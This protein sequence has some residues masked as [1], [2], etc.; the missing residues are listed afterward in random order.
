MK[1]TIAVIGFLLLVCAC[2]VPD[3]K[4]VNEGVLVNDDEKAL[5]QQ[6]LEEQKVLNDSA[7]IYQDSRLEEYL[8]TVVLRLQPHDL[9][10]KLSFKMVVVKDPYFNAF[11][12]PNG[13]IYIHTGMLAR[14]DNE[15]QLAALLA[16][17]MSHTI[18][19]HTLRAYRRIKDNPGFMASLQN[20]LARLALVEGLARFLGITGSMAA[21]TGYARELELEA[22]VA[23]LDYLITAGYDPYQAL[24][25]F[26]HLKKDIEA[27]QVKEPYFFGSHPNIQAR[28]DN[29]LHL[30]QTKYNDIRSGVKNTEIFSSKVS[31]VVLEN[32]RLE[33]RSGRF[34]AAQRSVEK[35]L[36]LHQRD[37]RAHYLMGEIFRQRGVGQDANRALTH[38]QKAI[39]IDS[40]YADPHKAIGLIHFKKGQRVLAR[41][42]FESCLLLAPD[43]PDKAY[44]QAYIKQ[45]VRDGGG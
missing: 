6:A 17:E 27:E 41:K 40:S 3:K 35:Y 32:A 30:L 5:W 22:D 37:A 9:P 21:I 4:S 15:A 1:R 36:H 29:T 11:A 28:I 38:Y 8:N 13:V 16:H 19:R 45:C 31:P 18:Q 44:I 42:Y 23:G 26:E 20:T 2:A 34:A 43:I 10:A 7:I 39:T 33:L 24:H 25:L 12:F 14:M